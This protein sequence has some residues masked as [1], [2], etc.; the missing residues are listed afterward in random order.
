MF[1]SA[2]S[3]LAKKTIAPT[4]RHLSS[5]STT[6]GGKFVEVD[7]EMAKSI[8]RCLKSQETEYA[9]SSASSGF[10]IA[11]S[12]VL[13][14]YFGYHSYYNKDVKPEPVQVQIFSSAEELIKYEN[15]KN[16]DN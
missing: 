15:R 11:L 16:N 5:S 10:S 14:G 1:R 8:N 2:I 7:E 4:R 12:T 6:K 3:K 13:I 9:L